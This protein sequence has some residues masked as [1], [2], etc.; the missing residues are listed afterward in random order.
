MTSILPPNAWALQDAKAR[1]SEL[2][3]RAQ[4]DGPQL[5]TVHGRAQVIVLSVQ[6]FARLQGGATGALLI[7][8]MQASPAYDMELP[9]SRDNIPVRDVTL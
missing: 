9:V 1:L 3:R 5:V 6:E 7:E 4:A 8:A 2:V